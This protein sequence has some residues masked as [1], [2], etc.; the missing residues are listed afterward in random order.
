MAEPARSVQ[1]KSTPSAKGRGHAHADADCLRDAAETLASH[2][3][4]VGDAE[5]M[6]AGLLADPRLQNGPGDAQRARM[7]MYLQRTAGNAHV[8]RVM[9]R[10]QPVA[11]GPVA[12][13]LQAAT[14]CPA[15][16]K[17][18]TRTPPDQ[19]PKFKT[20]DAKLKGEG[21]NLKQHPPAKAKADEAQGA[22]VPPAND[23]QSQAKAAQTEKMGT[24]KPGT[25]DKAAFVAAVRKAIADASPKTLDDADKF[26]SSG[27]AGEVKNQVM[28]KVSK[29]K[30]DSAKDVKE[31]SSEPPDPSKAKPKPVTPM[32]AETPGAKPAD[33]GAANAMP[34]PA[35][36][37]QTELGAGAC[38][39]EAKMAEAGVTEEHLKKSN[40]PQLQEAVEAKKAGEAH[41]ATA[42]AEFRA[43]EQQ[44]LE[45]A[46]QGAT[47]ETSSTLS[48]MHETR[49]GALSGVGGDK[50]AT[51]TQDETKRAE[52]STHIEGLYNTTKTDVDGILNGLD[53][54]VSDAFTKG[55]AEARRAFEENQK[56]EMEKWKDERYEGI[57]GAA[58][59][60]IDLFKDLPPEAN[61]IYQAARDLYL[62]KMDQTISEVADLVGGE[63]T[64]AKN[65]IAQGRDE[66]TTYVNGLGPELRAIGEEAQQSIASKFDQLEEDVNS[67]QDALAKDLAQKYVE[68]RTAVDKRIEEMQAENRGLCSKASDAIGGA[69]EVLGQLKDLFMTTLARAASAFTKILED[70]LGFISNFMNAVK[71]GFMGFVTNIGDHLKKG[72]LGWLFGALA[73][74]G[75]ELPDSFD[76]K[77]ILKMVASILGLTW[78]AIKARLVRMFPWVGQVIDFIESKI[79]IVAAFL[80]DGIAGI[81]NWIKDRLTDLK[82]MILAPIK[83]FVIENVVKAGIS[84][85]LGLLSPA[86][87]LVKIVQGL[88]GVVQWIME[89]GAQL[90]NLVRTVVDAVVDIANGGGGGIPAKIESSLGNAIPIVI[91]FLANL[92]GLGGISDKI[93][94]IIAAVQQPIGQAIDFVV[95]G[96]VKAAKGLFGKSKTTDEEGDAEQDDPEAVKESVAQDLASKT[97]H[98]E[99]EAQSLIDSTFQQYQPKGLK[100]LELIPPEN[101]DDQVTVLAAA[102][103]V[104]RIQMAQS[105]SEV[106]SI[107][108]TL[109]SRNEVT[110]A[111]VSYDADRPFPPDGRPY[112]QK[113]GRAGHVELWIAA[114]VPRLIEAIEEDRQNRVLRTAPGKRVPVRIDMNRF[115][116]DHC[117]EGR[118]ISAFAP[119]SRLVQVQISAPAV[120]RQREH[121]QIDFT[122]SAGLKRLLDADM[123]IKA[124]DLWPVIEQKLRSMGIVEIPVGR[125]V[126]S[127]EDWL[128]KYSAT[129]GED[130][131][132]V[133]DILRDANRMRTEATL[134]R[135]K[136][137]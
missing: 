25:F 102:S 33:P 6:H 117:G 14:A 10:V 100:S 56:T 81:W 54:K 37:E 111:Y 84:W 18:P 35:P 65:R 44:Q 63:L 90:A 86:G 28:D 34:A 112:R 7:L 133:Q 103:P 5:T 110:S 51:K 22:A 77:G 38:E 40:E 46:R 131:E 107:A 118:I 27:K 19:D 116:C 137:P 70:P 58:Q 106:K 98:G 13:Q 20:F 15:P 109:W 64:K 61:Q 59:W 124:L 67:K 71:S 45:S 9:A 135:I 23:T 96:A 48:T 42:P 8:A 39:T 129:R 52:V 105:L 99:E 130:L 126:Y 125:E 3:A 74:A 62:K 82:D 69:L 47:A 85:I 91:S 17:E 119:Y 136:K 16:A 87:A 26:A 36:K 66:I 32:V 93:K 49:S 76:L 97:V 115:P 122:S 134:K 31:K 89:R 60:A 29:G 78:N 83:E 43:Q 30:E 24:A 88:V 79:E 92:L 75:I 108:M 104:K 80:R 101:G 121:I 95:G 50:E 94:S 1:R 72:L 123:E 55:E 120:W 57:D 53:A 41:S 68:A 114:D 113:E 12:V 2:E 11:P 4:T 21:K 127:L 73:E 132:E 128:K